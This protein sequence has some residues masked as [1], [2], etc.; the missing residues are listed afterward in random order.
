L[1]RYVQVNRAAV[2]GFT[3]IFDSTDRTFFLTGVQMEI[4]STATDF[5]HRSY[6]EELALCQRYLYKSIGTQAYT[7]HGLGSVFAVNQVDFVTSYPVQMRANATASFGGTVS[8][9]KGTTEVNFSSI[10]DVGGSTFNSFLRCT[11]AA[12]SFT[13]GDCL[14]INNNNDATGYIQFDAEL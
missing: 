8:A 10:S 11:L 1:E 6:G 9:A 14:T 4:G 13:I 2:D 3:S 7:A 5:E 12:S